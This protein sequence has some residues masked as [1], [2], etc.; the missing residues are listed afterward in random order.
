[1]R[2]SAAIVPQQLEHV[3]P[4]ARVHAVEGLVEDEHRGVVHERGGDLDALAHALGVGADAPVG[5]VRQ[6]DQVDG[7]L[8]RARRGRSRSCSSALSRTN[9]RPVR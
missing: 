2:P 4:L 8:G 5:G 1:M 6:V 3:Q 7:P 9:S